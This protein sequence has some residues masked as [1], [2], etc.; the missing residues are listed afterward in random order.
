MYTLY[1]EQYVTAML[2]SAWNLLKNP[3]NLDLITPEDLQFQIV[4]PVPQEMFNGLI[5]EYRI[6]TPWFGE[7]TWVAEIKHIK[8]MHSFVDE[9]RLG[10]YTFWYHYHQIDAEEGRIKLTDR[11]YY[12]I[13]YG[14]FGKIIH[15]LFIRKT[16]KRIFDYR[17]EKLEEL[18]TITSHD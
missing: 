10:P 12:E 7:H 9:Q 1:R 2:A 5:I 16:L 3:A 8:A 15:F 17:K 18:L 6:K 13:P 4:S 11:V 14:I